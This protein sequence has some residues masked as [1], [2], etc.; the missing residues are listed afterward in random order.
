MTHAEALA[1]AAARLS[2]VAGDAR[3]EA[4]WLLAQLRA[5]N[6][7]RLILDAHRPLS[8]EDAAD[9]HA[10]VERRACGEPLAYVLGEQEFWSLRLRVTPAVLIPRPDTET[11]V[12][13]ALELLKGC[14]ALRLADLGTGSGAI[15]CA[16]AQEL[17]Q[18]LAQARVVATDASIEAL[19]LAR[20]N[21]AALGL[22]NVE[23]R[24]GHWLAPLAGE[25]FDLIVSNPPYVAA[26]DPHLAALVHEPDGALVSGVDGLDAIREI[27]QDAA[28]HLE[29]G[30]W[31]LLEHGHDQGAAVRALLEQGGYAQVSTRRDLEQRER[32][33]GGRTK[34]SP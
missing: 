3:R 18:A 2:G 25:R 1:A 33:T 12:E 17:V 15:A 6:R 10:L 13:W 7:A 20:E 4:E 8:A 28:A 11:L 16:L 19:Q 34:V 22:G 31:L 32:V 5:C 26:G 29:P 30:G 23:F 9:L 14:T 21:A 27:A 24:Q